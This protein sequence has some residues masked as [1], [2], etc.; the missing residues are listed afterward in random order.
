VLKINSYITVELGN[1]Q[2][3]TMS[4]EEGKELVNGLSKFIEDSRHMPSEKRTREEA[5]RIYTGQ[6]RKTPGMSEPKKEEIIKHVNNKLSSKP[7]TLSNLLNGV[8]YIPNHLP[9]IRQ[10]VEN[11]SHISKKVIGRRTYYFLKN[12]DSERLAKPPKIAAAV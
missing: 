9:I 10:L 5:L 7:R 8:S 12:A 6:R 4:L 2:K 3:I 1:G 11:E